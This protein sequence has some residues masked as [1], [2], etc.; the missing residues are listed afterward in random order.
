M[1]NQM[2]TLLVAFINHRALS[3]SSTIGD[4]AYYT[5]EKERREHLITGFILF[6]NGLCT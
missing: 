2:A 3:A 4:I 1:K 6:D 5:G